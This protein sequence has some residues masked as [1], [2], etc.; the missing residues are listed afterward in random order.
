MKKIRPLRFFLAFL[1]VLPTYV[2][3]QEKEKLVFFARVEPDRQ[4]VYTGDSCLVSIVLYANYP[5]KKIDD[6]QSQ[7]RVRGGHARLLP[8]STSRWQRQ[9]QVENTLYYALVWQQYVVGS[10]KEGQT[11]L[12]GL[13]FKGEFSII[14]ESPD[15]FDHFFGNGRR[16]VGQLTGNCQLT[17]YSLQFTHPP[18]RS[19]QEML[20]S[21]TPML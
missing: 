21:G 14:Y 19:T 10:E 2:Y 4:E 5:F 13:H 12:S 9:V 6:K 3:G 17:P 8:M 18:K 7:L 20:R 16:E 15:L 1:F 11:R